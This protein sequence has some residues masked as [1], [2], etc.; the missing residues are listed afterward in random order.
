M[1]ECIICKQTKPFESYHKNSKAKDGRKNECKECKSKIDR[2]LPYQEI[3]AFD[4]Y[5]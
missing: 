2:K 4:Y 3:V 5:E 1:K